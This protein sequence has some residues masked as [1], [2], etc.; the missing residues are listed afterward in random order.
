MG[1][2]QVNIKL[3]ADVVFHQYD[4]NPYRG[5]GRPEATYVIER[6]IDQAARKP[7]ATHW[8]SPTEPNPGRSYAYQT[9]IH[10]I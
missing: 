3:N 10:S 2:L 8:H 6:L 9:A 5:F 4:A 7:D 1:G